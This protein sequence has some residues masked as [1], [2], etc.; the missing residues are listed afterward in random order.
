MSSLHKFSWMILNVGRRSELFSSLS[1]VYE[2]LLCLSISFHRQIL[3]LNSTEAQDRVRRI[4]LLERSNLFRRQAQR[5]RCYGVLKMMWLGCANN[6]RSHR[7]AE[8]PS[9]SKLRAGNAT[10]FC[11]LTQAVHNFTVSFFALRVHAL[12]ELVRFVA[13]GVFVLPWT[14]QAAT[15]ERAPGNDADTLSLAKGNHLALLFAIKQVVMILHGNETGPAVKVGEIESFREL[16]CVHGRGADVAHL[17]RFHHVVQRL[18]S[19]FDRCFIIPAVNLIQIHKVGLQTAKALVEFV[20]DGF[21]GETMAV[22]FVAHHAVDLGGNDNGFAAC[23]RL[24]ETP[25][26]LLAGTP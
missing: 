6:G 17:A 25:E 2:C 7:L 26:H 12:P 19:F 3:D 23:V 8:P 18:Q 10:L 15:R 9:E 24:Q 11:D 21:A 14:S 16:P 13:F 5:Q 4:R 1:C 20:K 22:G